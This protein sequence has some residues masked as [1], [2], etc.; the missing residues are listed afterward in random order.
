MAAIMQSSAS[1]PLSSITFDCR[2]F[3]SMSRL[4][5]ASSLLSIFA[6]ASLFSFFGPYSG[7]RNRGPVSLR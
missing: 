4:P 5:S 3:V 1:P 6:R 2:A 7:S